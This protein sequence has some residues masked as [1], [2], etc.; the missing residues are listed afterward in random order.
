MGKRVV[1][2]TG[3]GL[4][5]ALLAASVQAATGA[6]APAAT[7]TSGA[8]AVQRAS[9]SPD[10]RVLI[11]K[12]KP[13]AD[14]AAVTKPKAPA[15]VA[16][17]E[18]PARPRP[19]HLPVGLFTPTH[20]VVTSLKRGTTAPASQASSNLAHQL[21]SANAQL[22]SLPQTASPVGLTPLPASHAASPWSALH[23]ELTRLSIA[24]DQTHAA[25][26][27]V[28]A[29]GAGVS[30]KTRGHKLS[31]AEAALEQPY[32]GPDRQGSAGREGR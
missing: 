28:L 4:L 30:A 32:P 1:K 23:D 9:L 18:L 26:G 2:I 20:T 14:K 29:V 5:V 31:P 17:K 22:H 12:D 7:A 24:S 8:A 11:A 25:A 10:H 21:V 19:F 6:A 3:S 15:K 13:V 16:Y 27:R